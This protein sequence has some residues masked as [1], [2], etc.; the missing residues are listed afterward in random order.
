M[1][2]CGCTGQC[3]CVFA[4]GDN[5]TISGT[6]T[7]S[8]PYIISADVPTPGTTTVEVSP[9][10][11]IDMHISGSGAPGDPYIISG[12]VLGGSGGGSI[13]RVVYL[14]APTGTSAD[15]T[16]LAAAISSM[17]SDPGLII[18][19]GGDYL[20]SA[21]YI[22]PNGVDLRG[23]GGGSTSFAGATQFVA[24]AGVAQLEFQGGGGITGGFQIDGAG[25]ATTPF[26]RGPGLGA[27]ARTFMNLVV[28]DNAVAAHSN[29][30]ALFTGGQNDIWIQCGFANADR[31][32]GVFDMGYG[33]AAFYRCEWRTA[34]RYHRRYDNLIPGGVGAYPF[35][36]KFDHNIC[37][38]NVGV[39]IEK[40]NAGV[41]IKH[42]SPWFY[43]EN[44]STTGAH[45]DIGTGVTNISMHNAKFQSTPSTQVAGTKAIKLAGTSSLYLTG[46]T[47]FYNFASVFNLDGILAQV[48]AGTCGFNNCGA[49]FTGTTSATQFQV[50]D[51]PFGHRSTAGGIAITDALG[52]HNLAETFYD[53]PRTNRWAWRDEKGNQYYSTVGGFGGPNIAVGPRGAAGWGVWPGLHWLLCTGIGT[54]TQRPTANANLS[55]AVYGNLDTFTLEWCDGTTWRSSGSGGGGGTAGAPSGLPTYVVTQT[56]S[57]RYNPTTGFYNAHGSNLRKTRAGLGRAMTG[58]LSKHLVIGDSLSAACI[59]GAHS[60]FD[61][62]KLN[63]WPLQMRAELARHGIVT[64]GT[65]W[66]RATDAGIGLDPRWSATG[67]WNPAGKAYTTNPGGGTATFTTNEAGIAASIWYYDTGTT[68]SST[69]SINGASSGPGFKTITNVSAGWKIA[70]LIPTTPLAPGDTVTVTVGTGGLLLAAANVWSPTGLVVS[71]I[72]QSSS[73]AAGT[74]G[75]RWADYTSTGTGGLGWVYQNIGGSSRTVTDLVITNGSPTVTSASANFTAMDLGQPLSVVAG[76]AGIALP[77]N[78]YIKT[79]NSATSVDLSANAKLS[80]T[81]TATIG[82]YPDCVHIEIGGNDLSSGQTV[83]NTIAAVNTIRNT[84][85]ASDCVLYLNNAPATSLVDTATFNSWSSALYDLADSLDAVLVDNHDRF[86]EWTDIQTNNQAGD[87]IA[88]LTTSAYASWGRAVGLELASL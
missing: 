53:A 49:K 63:A 35:N 28:H 32:L 80:V 77:A 43:S 7:P 87:G 67:T 86:G 1:A 2:R 88:H 62:D 31:D 11:T 61:F 70:T 3:S 57:K 85:S 23:Q 33:G 12:D 14:P 15:D 39:S 71:N 6:G 18:A 58:G 17:G 76:V 78:T 66:V 83:A 51:L 10:P 52:T 44:S 26:Q 16:A 20:F 56:R 29:D 73:R 38:G 25:I 34:G 48:Y 46:D 9:T 41:D 68:F 59:Q 22:F 55:G 74:G 40:Y 42:N 54:T 4:E 30:L 13:A 81:L 50:L 82:M 27:N 21:H 69:I 60:P 79:I 19:Q 45:I 36:L 84:Y 37:E 65:G 24:A 47:E 64:S 5:V 75:D 8:S 72:A